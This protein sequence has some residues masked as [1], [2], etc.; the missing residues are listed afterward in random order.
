[1]TTVELARHD[2]AQKHKDIRA[3][4]QA[5]GELPTPRGVA[6]ELMRATRDS[7][8][9]LVEIARL[10]KTD[11][12]LTAFV[13]RA[14]NAARFAGKRKV[15]DVPQAVSRLGINMVRVYAIAVSMM[16]SYRQGR[17]PG[18]DYDGF[19]AR[20][21][22]TAI[23][24]S[25]LAER[26]GS[27]HSEEAFALALLCQIGQLTFATAAPDDYAL[28]VG[29]SRALG[30][31]RALLERDAFG[32]DQNELTAVL[33]VEWGIPTKLADVVFWQQDPE[34][35][36]YGCNSLEHRLASELRLAAQLAE[37]CLL[38]AD[39]GKGDLPGLLLRAE[40]AG[41]GKEELVELSA[42]AAH[43]WSAWSPELSMRGNKPHPLTAD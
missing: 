34:A 7:D 37:M 1:M 25:E 20:S 8:T 39:D 30:I 35:G 29:R 19:W 31:E 15:V 14:A 22:L 27:L 21:L 28:V 3:F 10:V 26:G 9:S 12:A 40:I 18:F 43:E 4:I 16:R 11:P 23:V 41:L 5:S 36:G 38:D 42:I 17:C 33:L 24:M 6:L 13:I 32:F 2:T